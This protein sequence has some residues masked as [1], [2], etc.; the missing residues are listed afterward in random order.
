MNW[1]GILSLESRS[2]IYNIHK[3][4]YIKQ[5]GIRISKLCKLQT[6]RQSFIILINDLPVET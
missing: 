5:E 2:T 1:V 6:Q 3:I 4:K